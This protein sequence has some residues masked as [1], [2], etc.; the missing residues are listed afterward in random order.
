MS[1]ATSEIQLQYGFINNSGAR[2]YPASEIFQILSFPEIKA[3]LIDIDQKDNIEKKITSLSKSILILLCINGNL[4]IKIDRKKYILNSYSI[5]IVLPCKKLSL[6]QKSQDLS[7]VFVHATLSPEV[8]NAFFSEVEGIERFNSEPYLSIQKEDAI[9]ILDFES[10]IIKQSMNIDNPYHT[11]MTKKMLYALLYTVQDLHVKNQKAAIFTNQN[12]DIFFR[13]RKLLIQYY[14]IREP[15]FYAEKLSHSPV[16]LS[17]RIKEVSGKSV[18]E[19]LDELILQEAKSL[20]RETNTT[21]VS[22]S[23]KLKFQDSN[24]FRFFFKKRTGL[25]PRE[26]RKTRKPT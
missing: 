7:I 14:P 20:L 25:S 26:Y 23:Q 21:I 11:E 12:E 24:C 5:C 1:S 13:F 10:F 18:P 15:S 17:K 22:I 6:L 9:D 19:W 2:G 4:Q 16:Y 8:L 3:P